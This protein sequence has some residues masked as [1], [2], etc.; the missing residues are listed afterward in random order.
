MADESVR[1]D[2]VA[3]KEY[4]DSLL[5]AHDRS[6]DLLRET[7]HR[8]LDAARR[9]LD[10]HLLSLNNFKAE[11]IQRDRDYVRH[12]RFDAVQSEAG[13]RLH[14]LESDTRGATKLAGWAILCST[15]AVVFGLLARFVFYPR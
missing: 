12:D 4:V 6:N 10:Q 11:M 9:A 13:R 7:D 8:A 2:R 5:A 3:L 1:N 15:I 14:Q